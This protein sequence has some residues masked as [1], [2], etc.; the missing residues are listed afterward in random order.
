MLHTPELFHHTQ[1]EWATAPKK[2]LFKKQVAR[3]ASVL[4]RPFLWQ[5]KSANMA[6]NSGAMNPS[7]PSDRDTNRSLCCLD[8]PGSFGQDMPFCHSA[9]PC[10]CPWT[11]ESGEDA[12]SPTE[13]V[14][15][16]VL[17]GLDV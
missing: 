5:S 17:L 12:C 2:P 16:I 13:V 7:D 8:V 11:R 15:A 10:F 14:V 3:N 6:S 4:F 9:V 1:P